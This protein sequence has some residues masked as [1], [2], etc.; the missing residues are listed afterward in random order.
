VHLLAFILPCQ[1]ACAMATALPDEPSDRTSRKHTA[2]VLLGNQTVKLLIINL[3]GASLIFFFFLSPAMTGATVAVLLLPVA[4]FAGMIVLRTA[5]PPGSRRLGLFV[6][7]A[8]GANV[9]LMAGS[10][11][12]FFTLH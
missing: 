2:P 3:I 8:V 1:L 9:M 12:L 5:S 4:C 7:C 6:T 11:L 10:A